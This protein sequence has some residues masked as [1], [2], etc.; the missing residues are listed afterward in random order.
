MVYRELEVVWYYKAKK[1]SSSQ[2][3]NW[4]RSDMDDM[5]QVIES[6]VYHTKEFRLHLLGIREPL[7]TFI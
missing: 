2:R 4:S 1:N 3:W 7:K 5:S 6:F